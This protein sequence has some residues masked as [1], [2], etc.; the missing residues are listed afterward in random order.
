MTQEASRFQVLLVIRTCMQMHTR[1]PAC[2]KALKHAVRGASWGRTQRYRP[3][4]TC[5]A[6]IKTDLTST[7]VRLARFLRLFA[8]VVTALA[9]WPV[10]ERVCGFSSWKTRARGNSE[11]K[12]GRF[13]WLS[14]LVSE[15]QCIV[16]KSRSGEWAWGFLSCLLAFFVF[17][18][19]VLTD[20]EAFQPSR[21][22]SI[23]GVGNQP[24]PRESLAQTVL[25]HDS[26]DTSAKPRAKLSSVPH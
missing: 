11:L 2:R 14:S 21:I 1:T 19:S 8:S 3:A 9:K 15:Q 22:P 16:G 12:A 17:C 26:V 24:P 25:Q 23:S 18:F 7:H 4:V 20:E 13:D 10:R 5:A 6:E